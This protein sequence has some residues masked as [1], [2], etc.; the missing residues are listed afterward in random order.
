MAS[1][2]LKS[3]KSFG[4]IG[5]IRAYLAFKENDD[6]SMKLPHI[7]HSIRMRGQTSDA[8]TFKKI[9]L[10]K[11]YDVNLDFQPNYIVAA[12]ACIGLSPI[13]FSLKYPS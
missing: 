9:F 11:E 1:N 8:G 5:G 12:G 3:I 4:F 7:K 10:D 6:I 2:L 13:Y